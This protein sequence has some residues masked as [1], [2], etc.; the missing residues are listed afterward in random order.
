MESAGL[1]VKQ[2]VCVLGILTYVQKSSEYQQSS[3]YQLFQLLALLALVGLSHFSFSYSWHWRDSVM[4]ATRHRW[5]WRNSAS[6]AT[7]H[8]WDWRNSAGSAPRY[9][10]GWRD[11]VISVPRYPGGDWVLQKKWYWLRI[12]VLI[13][14]VPRADTGNLTTLA[15]LGFV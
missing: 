8:S 7:R 10:W 4:S 12:Y 5:D 9:P 15:G 2:R 1:L 3:G 13:D 11:L 6:S 14:S